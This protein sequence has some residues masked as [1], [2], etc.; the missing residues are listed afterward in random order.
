[1]RDGSALPSRAIAAA[2]TMRAAPRGAPMT[3]GT[4]H[5]GAERYRGT[6]AR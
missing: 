2:T 3:I 1:M 6:C 4:L 5:D